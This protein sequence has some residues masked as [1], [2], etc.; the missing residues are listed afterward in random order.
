MNKKLILVLLLSALLLPAVSAHASATAY[1]YNGK[2]YYIVDGNNPNLNSGDRVCASVGQIC[3]GYTAKTTAICKYIHPS[4]SVT[5]SVNGNSA[6]F[7]CNGKPQGYAACSTAINNC[8]ICPACGTISCSDQIGD[9]YAQMFVECTGTPAA[10]IT[11]V[12]NLVPTVS[13]KNPSQTSAQSG[14]WLTQHF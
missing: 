2:Y 12:S 10:N 8:Q 9:Q 3:I 11:V 14:N 6:G 1:Q 5:T 7:Y 4:A 13:Q